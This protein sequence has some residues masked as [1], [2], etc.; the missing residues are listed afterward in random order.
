VESGGRFWIGV[1]MIDLAG[2]LAGK[3]ELRWKGIGLGK[4]PR[5]VEGVRIYEDELRTDA[6]AVQQLV[7]SS[8]GTGVARELRAGTFLTK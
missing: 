4:L 2:V 3:G 1:G 7:Y 6:E 5:M 8:M